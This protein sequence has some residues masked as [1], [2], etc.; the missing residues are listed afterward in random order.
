VGAWGDLGCFSFY[1]TKN[2]G[3]IGD[4]G[5]VVSTDPALV[6]RVR[7]RREYGWTPQAR[8]V[9]QT[10]GMNSRLD[11]LQAAILRAK[12]PHLDAWNDRRRALAAAYTDY[13][14]EE[15]VLPVR[16]PDCRHVYHLYVVRVPDRDAFRQ[17][18]QAAGIGTGIHYPVPI[19]RQ[20]AY[21]GKP[22]ATVHLPH[23]EQLAE[24]IVSLPM[25]PFLTEEQ[26]RQV[27]AAVRAALG[28]LAPRA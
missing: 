19:H 27:A 16:L 24:E 11:E 12:L 5:A 2:L 20:P 18:L 23:T 9:S 14:P 22:G 7:R 26:V 28:A 17:H 25:H 1:P 3:A 10:T 4:G 21:A 13:L 15:V 8:Y 6:E